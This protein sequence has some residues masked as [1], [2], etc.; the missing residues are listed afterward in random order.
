MIAIFVVCFFMRSM[1]TQQSLPLALIRE[2]NKAMQVDW[3]GGLPVKEL[4]HR[5]NCVVEQLPQ[6]IIAKKSRASRVKRFFTERSF[7]HYQTLGCIDAPEK[8]GRSA[9][10]GFRHFLQALLVR[11]LLQDQLPM[12]QIS[13]MLARQGAAELESM[14]L[15][16]V[17]MV[18]KFVDNR[19]PTLAITSHQQ[20]ETWCRLQVMEGVELQFRK[21]LARLKPV[22]LRQVMDAIEKALS[23]VGN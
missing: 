20:V 17:E 23:K 2:Y 10:Y 15:G 3:D 14:F 5:V 16:G 21:E 18:A 1:N 8:K 19:V 4:I 13:V 6:A 7:R 12:K 9:I 22:E 11:K